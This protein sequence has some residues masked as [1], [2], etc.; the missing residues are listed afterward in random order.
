MK[1]RATLWLRLSVFLL[2]PISA[3]LDAATVKGVILANEVGGPPIA[4]VQVSAVGGA[5]AVASHSDGTFVLEFP[6]KQPGETVQLIVQKPGM[7]VVNDFQ[8][9]LTLPKAASAAPLILLL[10]RAADRE[11]MARRFYQLRSFEAIEQSYRQKLE[12]LRAKNRATETAMEQLRI[13]REQA[14]NAAQGAAE[15]LARVKVDESSDLYRYAVSLFAE[16]KADDALSFLNEKRLAES[17]AEA[18]KRK[19]A[20]E[21]EL[22]QV[23]QA[24]ALK[25]Q[26]LV[27]KFQFE[28]AQSAYKGAIAIAPNNAEANLNLGLFS[29][30]L[31]RLSEADSS[32]GRALVLLR[33]EGDEGGVATILNNLG[34]LRR[35]QNRMGDARRAYHEALEIRRK[36]AKQN[37][38]TYLP[39][40]ATTL[41]NLGVLHRD[42]NRM[43][44]ARR[45]FDEALEIRR[46]LV[47]QSSDTYLPD[48]AATL[49][50]LGILHR[51]QNRLR[52]ARKAYDEALEIR[53]KLAQKNPDA[54]LP[55]VAATLNNLGI[56]YSDQNRMNEARRS[57]DEALDAYRKLAKQN[58][59]T[60]LP[61]VATALN[62]LGVLLREQNRMGEAR[63]AFSE[64]LAIYEAF[65]KTNPK[66]YGQ[67][68]ESTRTLL[69]GLTD[70]RER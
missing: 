48:V 61:Y 24:Y 20:A 4:N 62:N 39:Y 65:A 34:A 57:Y 47:R 64:S 31:N 10:C 46:K 19:A 58:P 55:D 69:H 63:R 40:V 16:G 56:L 15:R 37:P 43:E 53:R 13:E 30:K 5:N 66:K 42:Q 51:D 60:Y 3:R 9:R 45:A 59:A 26:L 70:K 14:K 28:E 29:Q 35:D 18:R 68:V 8:L 32:Y 41:N 54:Y 36:L 2:L 6:D 25:G 38:D 27:S 67:R 33:Q 52:E 1:S 44:E 50:N 49:N 23:V 12:D 17:V 11:E 22:M 21:N 7:V